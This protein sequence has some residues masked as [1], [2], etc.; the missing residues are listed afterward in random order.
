MSR[1]A[2]ALR[3]LVFLLLPLATCLDAAPHWRTLKAPHCL[4]L[5]QLPDDETREWA[6][7]FEQF[8][9][10]AR[11]LLVVDEK[12][13]T[14]L[15][16]V[17]FERGQ[18]D[19]YKPFDSEKRKR[20]SVAGMYGGG[21]IA[22]GNTRDR[23]MTRYILFHEATHWL[24]HASRTEVPLWLHEG[25][26]EAFATFAPG[27]PY[28]T[29]GLSAGHHVMLLQSGN[30]IPWEEILQTTRLD[31]I[32]RDDDKACFFYAEAWLFAH[33]LLFAD[34]EEGAVTLDRHTRARLHGANPQKAFTTAI[35][36]DLRRVESQL[37]NYV[38]KEQFT[39]R[40]L[41][42]PP[43]ATV[44][45]PFERAGPQLVECT[46]ARIAIV[47]HHFDI[48][49]AHIRRAR[50]LMPNGHEPYS[51]LAH[52]EDTRNNLSAAVAA[53]Q[54]A[55]RL[56]SDSSHD[57]MLIA[58]NAL[59]REL[60]NCTD[61]DTRRKLGEP[62]RRIAASDPREEDAYV[63][64]ARIVAR[65]STPSDED[66]RF[67]DT[68]RQL[69]PDNAWPF[70]GLAAIATRK[71]DVPEA[72]RLLGLALTR[73]EIDDRTR[74]ERAHDESIVAKATGAV[75][76][77]EAQLKDNQPAAAIAEFEALLALRI[78]QE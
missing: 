37:R 76:R 12:A 50:T 31:P 39:P 61:D 52:C 58:D 14:P 1:P 8:V 48:A 41:P 74:K 9:D 13:L 67:I 71:N 23:F 40:R 54:E 45:S 75:T 78:P 51:L 55:I 32:Y 20:D 7:E 30:W 15:T 62:Y 70:V 60:A 49:E 57:L 63:G 69:Y 66:A 73:G 29:L 68:G 19:R 77:I 43:K 35:E 4:L 28:G 11:G 10:A 36:K 33:R 72:I 17:L 34:P 18:F 56:G 21:V 22:L 42:C 65:L 3:I 46:L 16:I 47:T 27:K 2:R 26:S 53:A 64:Y 6:S 44:T 25:V 59:D 24:L 38:I 5:S